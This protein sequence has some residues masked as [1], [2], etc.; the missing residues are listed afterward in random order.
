MTVMTVMTVESGPALHA[1]H[2]RQVGHGHRHPLPQ[3]KHA[4]HFMDGKWSVLDGKWSVM[5]GKCISVGMGA[6]G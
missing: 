6:V 4:K 1:L 5:D 3:D 2:G